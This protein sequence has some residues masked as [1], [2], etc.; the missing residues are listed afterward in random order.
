M[1]GILC[2]NLILTK[3]FPHN[4]GLYLFLLTL[5]IQFTDHSYLHKVLKQTNECT[6][7]NDRGTIT[8]SPIGR[9][10][11]KSVLLPAGKLHCER[12]LC[13][14]IYYSCLFL[15]ETSAHQTVMSD[16]WFP[17][18]IG[19]N[20]KNFKANVYTLLYLHLNSFNFEIV[21]FLK[22]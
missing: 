6:T 9:Q 14:L 2:D 4:I 3:T 1:T 15:K 11:I 7:L 19:Y 13:C 22:V 16:L 20:L 10:I 17:L 5:F 18:P 12:T 21:K 8:I